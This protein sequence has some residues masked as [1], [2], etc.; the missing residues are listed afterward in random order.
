M[1][2][3]T[4]AV[5]RAQTSCDL[6]SREMIVSSEGGRITTSRVDGVRGEETVRIKLGRAG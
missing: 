5:W 1:R 2:G 4:N 3:S 6:C